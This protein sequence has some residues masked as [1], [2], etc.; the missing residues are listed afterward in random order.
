MNIFID[1]YIYLKIC[2]QPGIG[3]QKIEEHCFIGF[4]QATF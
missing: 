1:W 4:T 3:V 2:L